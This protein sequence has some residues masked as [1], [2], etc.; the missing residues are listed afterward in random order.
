MV[1]QNHKKVLLIGIAPCMHVSAGLYFLTTLTITFLKVP[2]PQIL[3][4]VAWCGL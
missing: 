3:D 2:K 1:L 4:V